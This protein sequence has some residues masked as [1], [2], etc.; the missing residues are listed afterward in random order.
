M[1]ELEGGESVPVPRSDTVRVRLRLKEGLIVSAGVELCVYRSEGAGE[2]EAVGPDPEGLRVGPEGVGVRVGGERVRVREVVAVAVTVAARV[3]VRERLGV[4]EAVQAAVREAGLEVK[5]C[6]R[7][8][9]AGRVWESVGV[10]V[11]VWVADALATA[12][13]ILLAVA[14]GDGLRV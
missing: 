12:L 11:R 13:A 10:S 7:S 3:R 8:R 14:V 2:R 6:E 1:R 9:V 5:V 4:T